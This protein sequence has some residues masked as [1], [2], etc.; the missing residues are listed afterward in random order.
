[1]EASFCII[2]HLRVHTKTRRL[3]RKRVA[4]RHESEQQQEYNSPLTY[5]YNPKIIIRSHLI[6]YNVIISSHTVSSSQVSLYRPPLNQL[7][8]DDLPLTSNT[9][10]LPIPGPLLG[11]PLTQPCQDDLYQYNEMSCTL[12]SPLQSPHLKTCVAINVPKVLCYLF[13]GVCNIIFRFPCHF[14]SWLTFP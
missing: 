14:M 6:K 10:S 13:W 12:P 2:V 7:C 9:P 5:K 8:H 11:L 4:Y 3:H 1:M